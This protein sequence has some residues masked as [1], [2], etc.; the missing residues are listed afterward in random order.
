[1]NVEVWS[2]FKMVLYRCYKNSTKSIAAALF[3]SQK[4]KIINLFE[5]SEVKK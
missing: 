3:L 4:A 5:F 1:M 2:L